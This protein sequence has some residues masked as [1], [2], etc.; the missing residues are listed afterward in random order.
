[1]DKQQLWILAGG[2]G[3][4]FGAAFANVGAFLQ[5]GTSVSHLTGDISRLSINL[6]QLP[7]GLWREF[8][9]VG[10][11]AAG[12]ILGAVYAGFFIH[13][14]SIDF[15]RP[16]GRTV[17]LIGSLFLVS[18]L[19]L[20]RY[21]WAGVFLSAFGCGMQNALATQ[22][23]GIILRTTHVTGLLTDFGATLGMRLRGHNI[24]GWK[25]SVPALLAT[26]FFLGGIGASLCEIFTPWQ[27]ILV[28]GIAYVMGGTSWTLYK[29]VIRP[30]IFEKTAKPP[31][32]G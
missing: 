3:L 9:L 14:L 19:L 20:P 27:P 28:A 1:M 15:T 22:Y 29:H 23:R 7:S 21:P 32:A 12:F 16:Y 13:H 25:I 31:Q 5:T 11:A 18:G 26:F 30:H 17:S 2:C 10:A 4:A 8:F 6:T 24:P